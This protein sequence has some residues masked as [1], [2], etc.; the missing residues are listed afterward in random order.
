MKIKLFTR[1]QNFQTILGIAVLLVLTG[2]SKLGWG[3]TVG[4]YQTRASGSWNAN[5][6]WQMWN[7]VGWVNCVAGDYPGASSGAGI[8][9]ITNSRNVTITANVP[10]TISSLTIPGGNQISGISFSGTNSLTVTNATAITSNS[11]NDYKRIIV[12]AGNFTTGSLVTISGGDTQDAY[13]EISTGTVTVLGNITLN[14]ASNLRNYILFTGAGTL[15]IGGSMSGGGITSTAGGGTNPTSGTVNYYGSSA[16]NVGAYT[17]FNITLS[18]G[19]TKSIQGTTTITNIL[20]IQQGALNINGNTLN[21]AGPVTRGGLSA[22]T[23]TGSSTSN[24]NITG[25]GVFNDFYFTNATENLLNLTLN[26]VGANI[27]LG[28]DLTLAGTLALTNGIITATGKTI[29][30]ASNAAAS[31]SAG[32]G[33]YIS[34]SLSRA[35][36]NGGGIYI[37]PLGASSCGSHWLTLSA[38]SGTSTTKV[39]F[40][41]T[42]ATTGDA[43]IDSPLPININWHIEKVSGTFTDAAVKL[44]GSEIDFTS[45][46]AQSASQTGPYSK[47]TSV[48]AAGSITAASIGTVTTDKWLAIGTSTLKTY[49]A[50]QTGG[51]NTPVTW[52]LDPSGTTQ[53]GSSIPRD[54]D[55][56]II[57]PGRT[58]TLPSNIATSGLDISIEEGGFLDLSSYQFISGLSKLSGQGTLAISSNIFPTPITTNTFINAGGGTTEYRTS[59]NLPS[60]STYNNL[61]INASGITVTQTMDLLLN[62]NLLVKNGT[63][64]INDNT[65]R[66]LHLTVNKDV[67][68]N[69]GAFITVGTGATNTT[70]NPL[71]I[72]G[73]TAPFIDYY[74]QQSHRIVLN[75]NFTN[76]GTVRFTNLTYPVFNAF[77][78]TTSGTTTGFATVYFQGASDNTLLCAGTTDFYNLVLDK[79]I[80]QTFKLTIY[81]SGSSYANF[82]LF[83]ANVAGGDGGGINPNLKKALW[84]RTGTLVLEGLTMIPSLTEGNASEGGATPNS[85][86]YIPAN[87][88]LI[89]NGTDVVVL[90]TADDYREVNLAYATAAPN[91]VSMGITAGATGCALSL[92]GKLQV[93][94]GY[95]STRESGGIITSSV[96][97]GQF[98]LNNGTVDAKQFL[99]STGSA[100]YQ[101]NGGGLILRGRFQRTFVYSSV[102]N[103]TDVS[104][105]TLS[106]VRATSGISATFGTFNMNNTS[107]VFAMSG[108]TIRIYD[109]CGDGTSAA[110]QKAF[111]VLSS[112]SNSNVTGGTIEMMPV[113]GSA[114]ATDSP[115]FLITSNAKLG[116]LIINRSSSTSVVQLN[117]YPLVLLNNL[118]LTSGSLSANNIDVTVAGNITIQNGTTYTT[119]TNTTI[120]NGLSTQT[121]TVNLATAFSLNILSIDKPAGSIVNFAGTQT[122]ININDNF[123]LALGTLN[124]NGNTINVYKNVFN[125]GLHAGTGK[126]AFVGTTAQTIDGNGI[127]N[128]VELN[129]NTAVTAPVS[130]TANMTIN[131]VLTFSRDKLFNIGIYNLTLNSSASIVNG[132]STRYVQTSGNSGDGGLTKVFSATTAFI[133]PVGAPSTSHVGIPKWTPA[134]IGFNTAPT[135]FGSITV[136]PV[137]Y[138]HPATTVNNQS[139]SYFWRVKSTGFVGIPINSVTH[140]FTYEQT[141]VAGIET[142]YIPSVYNQTAYTWNNGIA[143]NIN[144]VTNTISD[145]LSPTNSTNFLDGDYT[146]GDNITGGGT[147]GSPRK[148]FS[149]ASAAWN[150]N[151]TWSY[152]S[153]GT[154][155]PAGTTEEVNYPGPN[156]IVIIE[157]NKTVTLT[158]NQRCASLQIAAGSVLD[159]YTYSGSVFSMVLNHPSGNGLFRVTTAVTVANVPKLFS[160]PNNS[161]FSDFN[162]NQGTTEFY[163]I[164]GA[165]GALYI[166]PSNV[167]TYGNLMVTAKG[168]DNIVLPNNTLT[169]INGNLTCGGDNT[170]AWITMSWNTTGSP[171]Y[172]GTYNPTVEKTVH[173]T[174][175]MFI[176][177]GTFLFLDDQAPQHLIVDGNVTIA[178]TAV[179]DTYNNYPINNGTAVRLNSFTIGGSFI[180]NSNVNPSAR[181]INGN[182]YVNLTFWGNTNELITSTGGAAPNTIFNNVTINKGKSQATTLTCDIGGTLSTPTDNWLTLQNGT[183]KYMRNVNTDFTVSTVTPF[184]IPVTAAFHSE[185]T[186]ANKILFAN[187]ASNT[188]DVFLNGKLKVV[189]GNVYIGPTN[190]ITNNNNDIEYSGS[191]ASEIE[192]TGGNLF[193]NGQIRQ[194]ASSTAGILT[195]KQSGGNVTINGNAANTTNAKLEILNSGEF[196]M[197]AGT[198]TI[199]RGGG[200]SSFGDLFLR[201]ATGSVTGGDII[202]S[203]NLSGNNQQYLLD[204]TLP[205]NNLIITGQTIATV[206][207]ATV[208]LM[209]NPLVLNGNLTLTNSQSILDVNSVYNLPLTVKGDFT[210]NGIYNHY[211]NLTNFSGGT[212]TLSGTAATDFYDLNVNPVTKLTLSKDVTVFDDLILGNG[213]LEC[214]TFLVNVKGNITNNATYTNSNTT[215]GV[216][217]N[218]S[219]LQRL[220]G[221]G[222]FGQLE[223]NNTAGAVIENS[224]TLT[225]DLVLNN[226]IF[227]ITE[228]LLTLGQNSSI[229]PKGTAFSTTKM[230]TSDGVWSN[231]GI[232]KVFGTPLATTFIY[233]LGTPG[234]Y[235]P[236]VFTIT[237]NGAVGSIRVNNINSRHPAV[238]DPANVLKYYW[239]TESIGISGFSGNLM[240]YY[241][242]SDV[243]GGPESSYIAA[244]LLTPGTNWS[245]A[246]TGPGTDNVNETNHTITF[247]YNNSSNLT[248]QYTAGNDA[249]IP[250]IV[251]QYT[252][253]RDGNWTDNTIWDYSGPLPAYPCP[254]GGPNG[255]IVTVDHVVTA[256]ANYCFAYKTTINNKLKAVSPYYGHNFGSV[257]GD[258]TLYLES[259]VFPAGRYSAFID[260]A[261]NS[262][263]E[264]G[265]TGNYDI[266][267]TLYSSTPRILLSGTGTRILP[268]K[269]LIICKQLKIDD[270][271]LGSLTLDNSINN[272]KLTINGTFERY[273]NGIFNCGTGSTAVVS[274]E[275]SVAQTLGGPLGNFSGTSA[276]NDFEINNIS[277]LSI[278]T[279]GNVEVNGNLLLTNGII[280]TTS[281]NKLTVTNFSV[282]CVIPNGGSATSYIDG[283]FIKKLNQ[284]DPLFKFPVGKKAFGLGNN[285]SLR[286]TQTGTL[287]WVVEYFNPNIYPS[288]S[289]PLTAVNTKEYWNV[290]GVP[291]T[292]QA[293]IDMSW[294]NESD[295]TPLMTQNGLS[296]MRVA[297]HNGT[298]WIEIASETV[299]GSDNYNGSVETS[300]RTIIQSGSRNYTVACVNTPKPRIKMSPSGAVCGTGG[301]PVILTTTLPIVAPYTIDYSENG[302]AKSISPAS[303]PA[304]IPTLAAGGVYQLTGFT[305]NYPVGSLQTG[306]FDKTP[307]TTFAIPTTSAAG[308]DQSL[309]GAT[310][311]TLAANTPISGIGLWSIVSGSGGT[312]VTPTIPSSLFDGTNGSTYVLRWTISNGACISSD[313]VTISFPLL[314]AQPSGFTVSS[315]TVCQGSTGV[316]YS[317]PNDPSVTY[318]WSYSGTG[319]TIN[320][321]SNSV[322]VDYNTTATAGNLSVTAT[323]SCNTSAAR[324][325]AIS[326]NLVG[327]W[328]GGTSGSLNDWNTAS[329]WSCGYIPDLTVNVQV[330]NV[331]NKP[332]LS[333]GAIGAVKDIVIAAGSSVTITG[334]TL[335]IA[336][337][338]TNSGTF[339]TTA[340]TIEMK[341]TSAQT[342]DAN[343]FAGNSIE[344]LRVNNPAGVTL[345]GPLNVTGVVNA[346]SG[347]LIS[348]GNLTLISSVTQTALIDGTGTGAITG[349]V[350]MQRYLPSGYGYKYLSSPFQAA[351]VNELAD[352]VDLLASFPNLYVYDED[353]HR[354]SSGVSIYTTGWTTYV[355]TT[356]LLLPM[357]GYAANLGSSAAA[358]TVAI[359]GVVNNNIATTQ[360][361][362]NHNRS[363][364]L[365]F[366]LA[367]NPYPSPIDWNASAGWTKT[368]IDNALYFFDNGTTNQYTGSYSTYVNGVSSNS[369]AG[370][371]VSSM[372][373]FFIHVSDGTFPVTASLG[374][375]NRVR[376]NNLTPAFHKS[377][378]ESLQPLVRINAAFENAKLSDPAVLYFDDLA[379]TSFDKQLDALKLL[380]TDESVPNLYAVTPNSERLSISAIPYPVD[381]IS[382]YP[383]GIKTEKEDWVLMSA[384]QIENLPA[385]LRVYLSDEATR[386]VQDLQKNPQYRV[387]LNSGTIE[388]RFSL[389]FSEKDL[390]NSVPGEDTFYGYISNGKLNVFVNLATGDKAQLVISNVLGQ[391]M[392]RDDNF[393][394]GSYEIDQFLPSAMY[395]IT[396]YSEK[397]MTSKKIYIPK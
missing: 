318:N 155:V 58:V 119:G 229:V 328:L 239:E 77:P 339:T 124:D 137:G 93:D 89:L 314:A 102:A 257:Y 271:N 236:A 353:N 283:P 289:A 100:S 169:T 28:S 366:N 19:N 48:P 269:D 251:P 332:I 35:M 118:T 342:I 139:L 340:G 173:V 362:Y 202:F 37:F 349:N 205:L 277:G 292:S 347:N 389:L 378:Y 194:N 131:G 274:F 275:G 74:D 374:M 341:G 2:I 123:M 224:I 322:T 144:T 368:N 390:A 196:T 185:Y 371:I 174:G 273:N 208:K 160:F 272:R 18:G 262:T 81:T 167:T 246:A 121:F 212:Q 83:G 235:T 252:S 30:L 71:N 10:N 285:L 132:S 86:F 59:I 68:V 146:A 310:S 346:I 52:T 248:G 351:T 375:D 127:F 80:D 13:L 134:T 193:V 39:S 199:L 200:G 101:Q 113:T 338:I 311:A 356:N 227:D 34:G 217:L 321:T 184:T 228:Y 276:F 179:F 164:D 157:N 171:Y 284:G 240:L 210:N 266:N 367:G 105:S 175:D 263:I 267:A 25:I 109:V 382:K 97:P 256:N 4:D 370:N 165:V 87:G 78:P 391:V 103:L 233:P 333:T 183:F 73:G 22:G 348:S 357:K 151:T 172:S 162:N 161:D 294:N 135:T 286:A 148:F 225:K 221:T 280:S 29:S 110:Q 306:V 61:T 372:Q 189:W 302:V 386:L 63:F 303:F 261:G 8:V 334:N 265:G 197:S 394:D 379:L 145:W 231:V 323:N 335:Q 291:G 308:I 125:S 33:S 187:S 23:I 64:R 36:A 376:V 373:G 238:I 5:T 57:L 115:F 128:N 232:M 14:A 112:T 218:G 392:L 42:G 395:I 147:F 181:F 255:F 136:I 365:G 352:D 344:G 279:N 192:I 150:V 268:D 96:S 117:T 290:S 159:I 45:V 6:T 53:V 287:L 215:S 250:T 153:G 41:C 49:Y 98:I 254:V 316:I 223:L 178:P 288:F 388:N 369:I 94:N 384:S 79:G 350:T 377:S 203:N 182:N 361:L 26:R 38:V 325:I 46:V 324:N 43:T 95:L 253:N 191:G 216:I 111:D 51:W 317:V 209:V 304:T 307:V 122:V 354:D 381:S 326:V 67:T 129:N 158:A 3:Q 237:A 138:E 270:G 168:G 222:T 305:Y 142:N 383:L 54:N 264:Y 309:C 133:F 85:D 15:N 359:T 385:G 62:G 329:N 336:G 234:K 330:P 91:S 186:T 282:S 320:G 397:G 198:L 9:T 301:I 331:L 295:L 16:Q 220:S 154:S 40:A 126:I 319:A 260:C 107:N 247:N 7:G 99:G 156:S 259:F 337:G 114:P 293:Y 44:D 241:Y 213:T 258:G 188:N 343:V 380:N 243:A 364:T 230:I 56:V 90:T 65:A 163:D 166:L 108:G 82:R 170:Q 104:S 300:N 211:N 32:L 244:Q 66:R 55:F 249:A 92:Y 12:N 70:T 313:D 207:S 50:Y 312:V 75:G 17:Y 120:L 84:I 180:N 226:G 299:S 106:N 214:T 206:S 116:N 387:H 47:V 355:T 27:N 219:S 201:P 327:Q 31:L 24:L 152:T 297:E 149:I 396:L 363:F 88:A 281:T 176:N 11:V 72:I 60:Q 315:L 345:Q 296:D 20:D 190:N 393:K 358:K 298:D 360:T 195:Y 177:N 69:T 242:A 1:K 141:D 21:I 140:T 245:K 143:A 278:N 76:N 204:A 130:L